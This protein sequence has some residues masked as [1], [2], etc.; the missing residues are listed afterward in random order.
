MCKQLS[1][2]VSSVIIKYLD[3]QGVLEGFKEQDPLLEKN[4]PLAH[5]TGASIGHRIALGENAPNKVHRILQ[6]PH[7]GQRSGHLCFSSSG[8]SLHAATHIPAWDRKRLFNLC[9][10]IARPP[11]S[12]ESLRQL[13]NGDLTFKLKTP[14]DDGTTHLVFTPTELIE[15]LA[16]IIPPPR[17]H[18]LRYQ[19][20]WTG[21]RCALHSQ[22]LQCR[23][24]RQ[25]PSPVSPPMP[26]IALR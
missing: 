6:D 8:F 15:K 1:E 18:K 26:S 20:H 13:P 21:S 23:Y 11:L 22:W 17:F 10:Y 9:C 4:L 25:R 12:N 2:Q 3:A 14:W 24:S 5:I 19:G 7:E 16:A